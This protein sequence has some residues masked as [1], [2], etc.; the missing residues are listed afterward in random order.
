MKCVMTL[1]EAE[2]MG[3]LDFWSA[4]RVRAVWLQKEVISR[5]DDSVRDRLGVGGFA[6]ALDTAEDLEGFHKW[7]VWFP[8]RR[9]E[10]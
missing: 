5:A 7:L 8:S 6:G 1:F 9:E 10:G 4:I 3:F 2:G